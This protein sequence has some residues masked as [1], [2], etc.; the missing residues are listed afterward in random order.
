L[1]RLLGIDLGDRRIGIAVADT[2]TGQ[3]R[4]L[5]TLS[6]TTPAHDAASFARLL[7]EQRIDEIVVGLP[8]KLDGS[9]GEQ[10]EA[11]RTW[12]G[13]VLTGLGLPLAW[14]D[15]RLTTEDAIGR[16]GRQGRGPSG[17]PPSA[18]ARRAY[19]ARL[20]RE[21]AAQILQAELDARSAPGSGR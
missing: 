10:A 11:T 3:V 6:R 12:A 14:R 19:R 21:A 16:V 2:Q 9:A 7:A 18:G 17:G 4:P 5:L 13:E 15:E 1:T 20:D 8:L